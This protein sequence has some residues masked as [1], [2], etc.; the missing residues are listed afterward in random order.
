MPAIMIGCALAWTTTWG[1]FWK[2]ASLIALG[3]LTLQGV[4]VPISIFWTLWNGFLYCAIAAGTFF[5][6]NYKVDMSV[7]ELHLFYV[8]I[9]VQIANALKSFTD[10]SLSK[11]LAIN[12]EATSDT[13]QPTPKVP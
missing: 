2:C 4:R 5:I 1:E 13:Q 11:F 6:G 7:G 8:T 10:T 12:K 3:S 9:G